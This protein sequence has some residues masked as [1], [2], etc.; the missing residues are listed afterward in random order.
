MTDKQDQIVVIIKLFRSIGMNSEAIEW[1]RAQLETADD[2]AVALAYD[3]VFALA[4]RIAEAS[5]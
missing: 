3:M 4:T 2:A 5:L 1:A